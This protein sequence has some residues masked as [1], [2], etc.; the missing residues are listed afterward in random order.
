MKTP[1]ASTAA[2]TKTFGHRGRLRILA[3]LAHGQT[4]VCQMAAAMKIPVST[5]SGLLL[6]LRQGGDRKSVV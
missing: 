3:L 1:L 6:E 5:V 4:S 2:V